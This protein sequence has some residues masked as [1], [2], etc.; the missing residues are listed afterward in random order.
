MK[1]KFIN[2]SLYYNSMPGYKQETL[3]QQKF[4]EHKIQNEH[5][6]NSNRPAQALSFS[7]SAVSGA[8]KAIS[9][10]GNGLLESK[11]L[12]KLVDITNNNEAAFSAVF[13][14][15]FAGMLKPVLILLQTGHDDK[16]GQMIATKNF[17]SA[18]TGF[19][20]KYTVEGSFIK[21][22]TSTMID[23]I[24]LI[25]ETEGKDGKKAIKT[26][27]FNSEAAQKL[28]KKQLKSEHSKLKDK[29]KFAKET[30]KNATGFERIRK[31]A[32]SWKKYKYEPAQDLI[33]SRAKKLIQNIEDYHLTSYNKNEGVVNFILKLHDNF[34]LTEKKAYE[35]KSL[36][37]TENIKSQP[38]DAFNSL[39]KNFL[40]S[41]T[42]I[43]KAKVTSILLPVVL[44]AIFAKRNAQNEMAK[45]KVSQDKASSLAISKN[46]GKNPIFNKIQNNDNKKTSQNGQISFTGSVTEYAIQKSSAFLE[47]IAFSKTGQELAGGLSKISSIPASF[48]SHVESV[49][50]TAYWVINTQNSKKIHPDQKLGFNIHTVLVTIVS[51]LAAIVV[52]KGFQFLVNKAE[53]G[54]A[55]KIKEARDSIKEAAPDIDPKELAQEIAKKCSKLYH[56]GDIAEQLA[57]NGILG[58]E[59]D[60]LNEAQNLAASYAKDLNK[61]KSLLIFAMVVRFLVPVLTVKQSK[62]IKNFL[63]EHTKKHANEP[64][65]KPKENKTEKA[66]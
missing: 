54:Y 64:D 22:I 37:S 7:G 19:L 41:A 40:G 53:S 15:F 24:G 5:K 10:V 57:K 36:L 31:F 33:D 55:N 18:F 43:A 39:W 27:S 13:A 45:Q 52:D 48:M 6:E 32:R 34:L 46:I 51:S 29:F 56:S 14:L 50:L 47:K 11:F 63:V 12:N 8:Q 65:N 1:T 58:N 35:A 26:Q 2:N 9:K 25:E 66:A 62:K 61:F 59:K 38:S 21:K 30:S 28:A 42:A 23:N 44:A 4:K 49:L 17:L 60:F 20:I 16:D 3:G